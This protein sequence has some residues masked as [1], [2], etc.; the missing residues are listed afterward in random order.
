MNTFTK[1]GKGVNSKLLNILFLDFLLAVG[2]QSTSLAHK[3][4]EKYE[5]DTKNWILLDEYPFDMVQTFFLF[6]KTEFEPTKAGALI[7]KGP[8]IYHEKSFFL[9]GGYSFDK[10]SAPYGWYVERRIGRMDLD[11]QWTEAGKMNQARHGHKL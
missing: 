4:V 11:G 5:F 8:L 10:A 9:F 6:L 7:S 3:L 1:I 2:T